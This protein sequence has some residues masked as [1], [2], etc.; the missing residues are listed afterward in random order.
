MLDPNDAIRVISTPNG[1]RWFHLCKSCSREIGPNPTTALK[2]RS[3]FCNTCFKR[4]QFHRGQ[5]LLTQIK[6]SARGRTTVSLTEDQCEFLQQIE[7]C[8]YCDGTIDW[9]KKSRI[10]LDRVDPNRGYEFSNVVVCC[11]DCN[12]IKSDLLSG[13]EMQI[14]GLLL[15]YYR[16]ATEEQR[17][18]IWYDLVSLLD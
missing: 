6:I 15:R 1:K 18:E 3:G 10:N 12:R 4:Q 17:K 14:V 13:E 9:S 16:K 7:R 11:F 5:H 2:T 8:C